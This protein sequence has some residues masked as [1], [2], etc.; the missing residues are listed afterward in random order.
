MTNIV[1]LSPWPQSRSQWYGCVL[2]LNINL[3][4]SLRGASLVW[5]TLSIV[6]SWKTTKSL[7]IQNTYESTQG[8]CQQ[9]LV[10]SNKLDSYFSTMKLPAI[11]KH[12]VELKEHLGKSFFL[13]ISKV[14]ICPLFSSFFLRSPLFN[15][16]SFRQ[17]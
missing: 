6:A 10:C 4:N 7:P 17:I 12:Y 2:D 1:S 14:S 5:R 11:S 15:F 16:F 13:S 8:N 9:L 3:Q